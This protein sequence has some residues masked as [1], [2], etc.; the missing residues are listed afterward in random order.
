ME[1]VRQDADG[2]CFEWQARLDRTINLPQA[3]DVFDKKRARPVITTVKKNIPP[4]MLG[5]RYLD[6]ARL[7][8]ERPAACAKSPKR[9]ARIITPRG[10]FC[11]PYDAAS[12]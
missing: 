10:R 5:R 3:F 2:V 7:S 6:I 11:T 9:R 12:V 8:H 4:S 1:M